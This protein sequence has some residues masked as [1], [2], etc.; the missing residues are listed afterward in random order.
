MSKMEE[1]TN[2]MQEIN[3]R[4]VPTVPRVWREKRERAER[5]IAS[6]KPKEMSIDKPETLPPDVAAARRKR[7]ND[8]MIEFVRR[9]CPP[10]TNPALQGVGL[11]THVAGT[12]ASGSVDTSGQ[13]PKFLPI[14]AE[15]IPQHGARL[16]GPISPEV[17]A[18]YRETRD[19]IAEEEQVVG[20]KS[21]TFEQLKERYTAMPSPSDQQSKEES[22]QIGEQEADKAGSIKSMNSRRTSI[23][24]V[25]DVVM[26]GMDDRR[27][28]SLGS[29]ACNTYDPAR[30][31]RAR[32][33]QL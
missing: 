25:G 33:R 26:G 22:C 11:Y 17:K 13:A 16:E 14:R 9:P 24:S 30:D 23:A 5:L 27:R 3:G 10:N 32:A 28:M 15:K 7:I 12:V 20:Q 8:E 29:N 6:W 31:P 18:V 2:N 21:L 4:D 19:A 1:L